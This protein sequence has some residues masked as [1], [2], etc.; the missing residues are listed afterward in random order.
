MKTHLP[1]ALRKALLAA[2]VAVSSF[3]YNKAE[4]AGKLTLDIMTPSETK[5]LTQKA[6][7]KF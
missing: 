2:L 1:V 7:K 5:S 4:A 3:V 6:E